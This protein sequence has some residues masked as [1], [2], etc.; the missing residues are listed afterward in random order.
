MLILLG[1]VIVFYLEFGKREHKVVSKATAAQPTRVFQWCCDGVL[2]MPSK[3]K[4]V[5]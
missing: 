4:P 2:D 1:G 3:H 5:I